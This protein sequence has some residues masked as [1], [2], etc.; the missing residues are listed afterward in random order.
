MTTKKIYNNVI[1]EIQK[2]RTKNNKLWMDLMRLAFKHSPKQ[3]SKIV[4]KINIHDQKISNLLKKLE[5]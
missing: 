3:A 5:I 1:N 2:I 4:K